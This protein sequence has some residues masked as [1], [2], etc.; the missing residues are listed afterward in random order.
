[1]QQLIHPEV[2][3]IYVTEQED[4]HRFLIQPGIYCPKHRARHKSNSTS[5]SWNPRTNWGRFHCMDPECGATWGNR[6]FCFV[7]NGCDPHGLP[8]LCNRCIQFV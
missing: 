6:C 7:S 2:A 5:F 4:R 8:I 3:R 1:L